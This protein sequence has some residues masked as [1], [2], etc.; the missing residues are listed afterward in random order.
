MSKLAITKVGD[1]ITGVYL[2]P[3]ESVE[4]KIIDF[5]KVL[6]PWEEK[7]LDDIEQDKLIKIA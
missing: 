2:T 4:V 1:E 5:D 3:V 7:L 6:A